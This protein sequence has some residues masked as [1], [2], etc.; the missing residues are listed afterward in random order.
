MC[1]TCGCLESGK[2]APEQGKY[3]C[4]ECQEAG[5]PHEVTVKKDEKMPQCL[6]CAGVQSSKAHW[7][8]V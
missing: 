2:A 5:T 7:K 3:T 4:V 6:E 1:A 8:K